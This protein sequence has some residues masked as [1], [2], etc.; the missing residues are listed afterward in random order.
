MP[1]NRELK[2]AVGSDHEGIIA[3]RCQ[4]DILFA[5]NNIVAHLANAAC[6]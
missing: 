2:N 6:E 1:G 3:R 4:I 5:V